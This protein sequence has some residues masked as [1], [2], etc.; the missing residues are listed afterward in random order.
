MV[1]PMNPQSSSPMGSPTQNGGQENLDDII[2]GSTNWPLI[3][4]ALPARQ[5]HN[6]AT[7]ATT[8][9]SSHHAATIAPAAPPPISLRTT[10][11]CGAE[12][13]SCAGERRC[14]T[15]EPSASRGPHSG[16]ANYR[17]SIPQHRGQDPDLPPKA[18][19]IKTCKFGEITK[20]RDQPFIPIAP[21]TLEGAASTLQWLKNWSA[22]ICSTAAKPRAAKSLTRFVCPSV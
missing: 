12:S 18:P 21:N 3:R 17:N 8:G 9:R 16:H 20:D 11:P 1:L 22:V 5:P 6:L 4:R 15:R 14:S 10:S 19:A 7:N 13:E 2:R